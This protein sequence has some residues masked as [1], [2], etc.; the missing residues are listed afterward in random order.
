[1]FLA[2]LVSAEPMPARS[3]AEVVMG[4][5]VVVAAAAG[6]A[7]E[8]RMLVHCW[9]W[10]RLTRVHPEVATAVAGMMMLIME[11]LVLLGRGMAAE[12]AKW[13]LTTVSTTS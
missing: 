3:A 12:T 6:A 10:L 13:R 11:V 9:T 4:V 1:M 2:G 7:P 5:L 8:E